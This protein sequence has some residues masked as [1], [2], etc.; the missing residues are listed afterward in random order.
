MYLKKDS[1]GHMDYVSENHSKHL[2]MVN[3]IFVAKYRRNLLG[4]KKFSGQMNISH[5]VLEMFLMKQLK[6]IYKIK[7]KAYIHYPKG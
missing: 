3:L 2:L 7:D 4:K 5:V 6:N 1:I